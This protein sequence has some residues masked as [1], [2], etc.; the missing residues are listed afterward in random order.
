MSV[1]VMLLTSYQ[2]IGKICVHQKCLD[3]KSTRDSKQQNYTSKEI[4]PT[5][6]TSAGYEECPENS[7]LRQNLGIFFE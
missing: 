5:Q 1:G 3:L 6:I 2:D 4:L 7:E